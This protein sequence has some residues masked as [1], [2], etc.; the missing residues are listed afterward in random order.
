MY[1]EAQDIVS[2]DLSKYPKEH[3]KVAHIAQI[4]Q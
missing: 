2:M 3:Q 4:I 1:A